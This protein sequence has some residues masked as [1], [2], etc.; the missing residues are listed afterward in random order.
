MSADCRRRLPARNPRFAERT[1][2]VFQRRI[3]SAEFSRRIPH[4]EAS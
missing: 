3:T 4:P 2:A 1:S